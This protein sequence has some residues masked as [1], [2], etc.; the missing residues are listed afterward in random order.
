MIVTFVGKDGV[1]DKFTEARTRIW[2]QYNDDQHMWMTGSFFHFSAGD[3]WENLRGFDISPETAA[4]MNAGPLQKL[5]KPNKANNL[6][7]VQATKGFQDDC[8]D[9]ENLE[10]SLQSLLWMLPTM[11]DRDKKLVVPRLTRAL[12]TAENKK[13]MK[14]AIEKNIEHLPAI[15]EVLM[16]MDKFSF[17]FSMQ[18][19][20]AADLICDPDFNG[21]EK[22]MLALREGLGLRTPQ[23]EFWKPVGMDTA[24]IEI[25][26]KISLLSYIVPRF[27]SNDPAQ[28]EALMA[29]K[30]GLKPTYSV[31]R[32]KCPSWK[33][34]EVQLVGAELL[35]AEILT[36]G[37]SSREAYAKWLDCLT[38]SDLQE[39]LDARK[40]LRK[41][42]LEDMTEYQAARENERQRI[43][44]LR[45][46][47]EDQI[48]TAR[49]ERSMIFN[50]RTEKMELFVNP[51]SE[52][53][54]E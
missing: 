1:K 42:A 36:P 54:K 28:D 7:V 46:K 45:Q 34:L 3:G 15:Y 53:A 44:E 10:R 12:E 14:A 19:Q 2:Q 31:V 40:G 37:G 20:L 26:D 48:A 35:A 50:P 21:N 22:Q 33:D 8:I 38:A 23:E 32:S 13:A 47:M 17:T 43:A 11:E 18:S 29:F 16:K 6:Y 51:E 41:A 9:L 25:D 49:R 52:K 30:T 27:G 5:T 24:A 4:E 39:M